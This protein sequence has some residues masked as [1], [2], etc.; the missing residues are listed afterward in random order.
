M[1]VSRRQTLSFLGSAA[2]VA[3]GSS[4][5]AACATTGKSGGGFRTAG[6][7]PLSGRAGEI[8]QSMARS[9][10][11]AQPTGMADGS[12]FIVDTLGTPEGAAAA[13]KA[14]IA[15]G[16]QLIFGPV[17]GAE[18][19]QVL[20]VVAGQVPVVAFTN[21]PAM[22]GRGAFVFGVTPSQT[23][24][25]T[26]QYA[27]SQNVKRLAI[28]ARPTPWSDGA[29]KAAEVAVGPAGIKIV[30]VLKRD[31]GVSGSLIKTLKSE[32]DGKLP[33]A[34]L[35]PDGAEAINDFAPVLNEAGLQLLG[36]VQWSG[37]NLADQPAMNG[38]WYAAPDPDAFGPFAAAYARTYGVEPGLLAGLAF[39]AAMMAGAIAQ[40]GNAA[41]D[42]I[43]ASVGYAGVTGNFKFNSDGSCLRRLAI[44]TV[45][46]SGVRVV[47][48][49]SAA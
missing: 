12:F 43:L 4:L 8:G 39:D 46:P 49:V 38:A 41:R 21:D 48:P 25:A 42:T 16:A 1:S 10:Q 9:V 20:E 35:L 17:F 5:L 15:G 33:D 32:S 28:I 40:T 3:A 6:L 13:A 18:L 45:D 2:W 47:A 24:S 29:I 7:L 11:L 26:I 37:L 31:T 19:V 22:L 34:V 36:T 44:L 30:S 23:V 27:A 14:A